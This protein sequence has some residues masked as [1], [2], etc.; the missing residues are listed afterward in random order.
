MRCHVCGREMMSLEDWGRKWSPNIEAA[1]EA[2]GD[3][4]NIYECDDS[5]GHVCQACWRAN[6]WTDAE[7]TLSLD[8]AMGIVYHAFGWARLYKCLAHWYC[9]SSTDEGLGDN[10][11]NTIGHTASAALAAAVLAAERRQ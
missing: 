11:L 9:S 1:E 10:G 5:V 7:L 4:D 8:E 2:G 6:A 3:T